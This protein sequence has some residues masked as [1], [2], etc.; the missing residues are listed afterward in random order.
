MDSETMAAIAMEVFL[1]TTV[2]ATAWDLRVSHRWVW[3]D[4]IVAYLYVA[5][6]G[7][8]G[9][10]CA[11]WVIHMSPKQLDR[12][13]ALGIALGARKLWKDLT[14]AKRALTKGTSAAR[15]IAVH[16]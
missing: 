5:A 2:V 6:F 1:L 8:M 16:R 9:V 14:R 15:N 11:A 10:A 4:A 7:F 12:V 13:L 3:G